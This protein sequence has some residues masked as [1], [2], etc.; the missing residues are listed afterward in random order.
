MN[1]KLFMRLLAAYA[2]AW[3]LTGVLVLL[4]ITGAITWS[5]PWVFAP[6]WIGI[7]LTFGLFLVFFLIV[8]ASIAFAALFGRDFR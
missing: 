4:R 1:E 8:G 3:I 6:V 5:W 7:V 2:G